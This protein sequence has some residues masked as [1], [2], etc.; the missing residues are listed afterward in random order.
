[1]YINTEI[2]VYALQQK[3]I[4][5]RRSTDMTINEA[6]RSKGDEEQHPVAHQLYGDVQNNN[7]KTIYH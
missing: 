1:M 4:A 2:S 5:Y 7:R 3:K 6:F